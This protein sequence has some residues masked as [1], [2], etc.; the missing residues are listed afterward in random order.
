VHAPN[1]NAGTVAIDAAGNLSLRKPS[2]FGSDLPVPQ[3]YWED[4]HPGRVFEHGPRRVSRQEIVAFAAEFDPQPM[5]L[6]EDAARNTMVGGLCASGWH[7]CSILMRM[8][9]DAFAHRAAGMGA[10]GVDEVRWLAPIRPDDALHL[11][12][13]VVEA[14]ASRSRPDM[15]FVRFAFELFNGAGVRVMTL[16]SSMM[17]GRRGRTGEPP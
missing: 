10:P 17:M 1:S 5:H 3:L 9:V 7:A 11:R 6:D 8:A 13:T 16:G 2:S 4:F 15:G 12:A 14:R